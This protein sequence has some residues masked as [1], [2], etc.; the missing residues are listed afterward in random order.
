MDTKKFKIFGEPWK[1][2][3]VKCILNPDN[4]ELWRFG[5]TDNGTHTLKISQETVDGTPIP[6]RTQEVT[7]MHELVHVMLDEGQYLEETQNEP[8]VEW[9]AKCLVSLKE[10]NVL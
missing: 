6:K 2:Q 10:Q 4:P 1:I 9:L 8:L 3:W 7:K 5:E